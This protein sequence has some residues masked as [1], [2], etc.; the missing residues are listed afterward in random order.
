MTLELLPIRWVWSEC[1]LGGPQ[2]RAMTGFFAA[3]EYAIAD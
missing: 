3:V 1:H 2:P